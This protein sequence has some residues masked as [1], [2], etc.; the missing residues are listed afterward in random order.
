MRQPWIVRVHRR[1]S[2]D[3]LGKSGAFFRLDQSLLLAA[4]DSTG[5]AALLLVHSAERTRTDTIRP[6]EMEPRHLCIYYEVAFEPI[7]PICPVLPC[8]RK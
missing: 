1:D 6:T 2:L 8:S 5:H 3:A 4:Q 7:R